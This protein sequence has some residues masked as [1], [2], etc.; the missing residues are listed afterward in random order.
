MLSDT[1]TIFRVQNCKIS[2]REKNLGANIPLNG[3]DNDLCVRGFT[4][5]VMFG[6]FL[7]IPCMGYT[8]DGGDISKGFY[9]ISK[10][11]LVHK[12]FNN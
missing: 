10:Y 7:L 3:S 2:P 12:I 6:M 4:T 11:L 1:L 5:G 8:F 9:Y